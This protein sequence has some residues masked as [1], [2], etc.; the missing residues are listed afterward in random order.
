MDIDAAPSDE[1]G[2]IFWASSGTDNETG[3]KMSLPIRESINT[4]GRIPHYFYLQ[5][6]RNYTEDDDPPVILQTLEWGRNINVLNCMSINLPIYVSVIRDPDGL[7]NYSAAGVVP[8]VYFVC[9]LNMQTANIYEINYPHSGDL[10]QIF[11]MSKRRGVYGF[12]G[13]S[14][15]QTEE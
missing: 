6:D 3:K 12:D 13:I 15:R 9:T 14:I 2:N 1:R 5:S 11:P 4:N 10:C 7:S 8:G